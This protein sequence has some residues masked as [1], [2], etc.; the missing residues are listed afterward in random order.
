VLRTGEDLEFAAEVLDDAL[1]PDS[2][3]WSRSFTAG[4]A[5]I[6]SPNSGRSTAPLAL[7]ASMRNARSRH[8]T[9]RLRLGRYV[10]P[11]GTA[12]GRSR[13]RQVKV[14]CWTRWRSVR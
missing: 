2:P 7:R 14:P 11:D 8:D 10:D 5:P 9:G 3:V 4:S 13:G 1:Q 12:H 6:T